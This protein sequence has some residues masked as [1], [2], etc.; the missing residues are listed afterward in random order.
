[1]KLLKKPLALLL[2][3]GLT[4]SL[5]SCAPTTSQPSATPTPT[6]VTSTTPTPEAT[7]DVPKIEG[8][9]NFW[10]MWNDTEP[11][12]EAI[13]S[14]VTAFEAKY[15]GTK[16]NIQWAGRDLSKTL[17]PALEGG[18]QIDV[19]DYPTQYAGQLQPF[20]V[21]LTEMV[22]KSYDALDSKSLKEV[23][24]PA[25][26]ETPKKQTGIYDSQLAVGYK[27]W[28]CLVMYN[29]KAFEDAGITAAPK[30]W[31]E[32]DDACA[33][34]KDAGYSPITFDDAYAH[35][36]PGM[37]LA[38]EKGQDWVHELVADTT[39]EMWK[40]EAVLNMANAFADFAKKGYFDANVG[41]NKWPAGQ[42]DVGMG[43][44]AMYLNLTGLPGEVKDVTDEGFTWG[45]FNFPD[46]VDGKTEAA[47][48]APAG[49]TMS[50]IN[51]KCANMPLAEEFVAFLHASE[52]DA[53]MV[54]VGMTTSRLDGQ[55]PAALAGLQDTFNSISVILE[56][57]GGL[58]ANADLKPVVAEN[59]VKLAAG[60]IAAQQFADNMA[61]AAKK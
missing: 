6:P 39:G 45:A 40:D 53:T 32:F 37:Y 44:A 60:Q 34:L 38:R 14:I 18:Q 54:G 4:L 24:L 28:E 5:A 27:P 31:A 23:L 59:F 29:A 12:G 51:V 3:M 25:M 17:K 47:T 55:W 57:G 52:S 33:K 13:Q 10:T 9:I 56:S 43:K 35:W 58:E 41:G 11:N 26:L 7:P 1:M 48:A 42:M 30:T 49:C 50:S 15:P 19:F 22:S 46:V 8:E 2:A 20:C 21:D 61:A 36:L 16:I